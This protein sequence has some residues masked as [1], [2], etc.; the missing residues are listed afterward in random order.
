[1]S[2]FQQIALAI[3]GV[4]MVTT[5]L[6]PGRQTVGVIN[7]GGNVFRSSLATAMASRQQ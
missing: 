3:I 4:G 5:L 7:A 2:A 6:L 1:M